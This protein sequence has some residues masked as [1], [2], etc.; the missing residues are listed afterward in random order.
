MCSEC[1]MPKQNRKF[2]QK[3]MGG[4]PNEQSHARGAARYHM[5]EETK[6]RSPRT[7]SR[8]RRAAGWNMRRELESALSQANSLAAAELPRFLGELE[9]IRA[10]AFARLIAPPAPVTQPDEELLDI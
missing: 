8:I 7:K 9:E 10:I 1:F 3:Q 2:Q 5:G 4:S 6:F